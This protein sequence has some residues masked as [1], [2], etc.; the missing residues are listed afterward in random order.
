MNTAVADLPSL[1]AVIV[2]VPAL[3]PVATPVVDMDATVASRV[4]NVI[5]RPLNCIPFE[6]FRTTVPKEVCPTR[7]WWASA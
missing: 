5:V 6:S 4:P 7:R 2:A 1:V 3:S